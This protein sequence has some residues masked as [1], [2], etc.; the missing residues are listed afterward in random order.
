MGPSSIRHRGGNDNEFGRVHR[1]CSANLLSDTLRARRLL[2]EQRQFDRHDSFGSRR[3]RGFD[4]HRRTS[5]A[6]RIHSRR[7]EALG[8]HDCLSPNYCLSA[9][10]FDSARDCLSAHH[11]IAGFRRIDNLNGVARDGDRSLEY[12]QQRRCVPADAHAIIKHPV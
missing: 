4:R 11:P 2:L 12:L 8:A 3:W 1:I 7:S 6:R 9:R 10:D 5:R